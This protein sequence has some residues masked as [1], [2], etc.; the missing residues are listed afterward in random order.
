MENDHDLHAFAHRLQEAINNITEE[1]QLMVHEA[2]T[3]HIIDILIEEEELEDGFYCYHKARGVEVSGYDL[4]SNNTLNLFTVVSE[5]IVPPKTIGKNDVEAA[6]K[7]LNT[8]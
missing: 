4:D 6:F 1:K 5:R 3:E 2:F 7:R 8:F